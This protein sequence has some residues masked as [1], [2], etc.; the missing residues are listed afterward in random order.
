MCNLDC[1][2][3]NPRYL[4][5]S[6]VH[7]MPQVHKH[8]QNQKIRCSPKGFTCYITNPQIHSFY[9]LLLYIFSLLHHSS[10]GFCL[11]RSSFLLCYLVKRHDSWWRLCSNTKVQSAEPLLHLG[12]NNSRPLSRRLIWCQYHVINLTSHCD[13]W[14]DEESIWGK[15]KGNQNPTGVGR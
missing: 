10:F 3:S 14:K 13:V 5:M 2:H 15:V 8:T 7:H 11:F 6:E 4:T 1:I 9:S 12:V